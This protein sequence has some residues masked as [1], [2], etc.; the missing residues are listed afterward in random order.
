MQD[1]LLLLI[2]GL[3]MVRSGRGKAPG[4]WSAM[5]SSCS[6]SVLRLSIAFDH[7]P[8][9]PLLPALNTLD[10]SMRSKTLLAAPKILKILQPN[11]ICVKCW[12]NTYCVFCVLCGAVQGRHAA[13]YNHTRGPWAEAVQLHDAQEASM[14]ASLNIWH[15]TQVLQTLDVSSPTAKKSVTGMAAVVATSLAVVVIRLCL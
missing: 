5:T 3:R 4:T 8:D 15:T 14:W 12:L 1:K 11:D 7:V 6:R 10:L 13:N 2:E 9:A